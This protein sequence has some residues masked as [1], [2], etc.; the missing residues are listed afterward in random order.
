[1]FIHIYIYTYTH[2]YVNMCSGKWEKGKK[3]LE[4]ILA[5]KRE[6]DAAVAAAQERK[7]GSKRFTS[8]DFYLHTH[9]N[10]YSGKGGNDKKLCEEILAMKR[11]EDDMA[12]V[13]E[14]ERERVA[15]RKR[16]KEIFIQRD[17]YTYVHTYTYIC[18]AAKEKRGKSSAKRF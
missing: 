9:I 14:Q 13:Q 15:G 12:A 17:V 10:M 18:T 3:L 6:E 16:E 5:M 2:I 4:E 8:R 7:R 11:E 1:M